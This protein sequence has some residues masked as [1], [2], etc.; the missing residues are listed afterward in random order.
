MH[1]LTRY[2]TVTA[3]NS[4]GVSRKDSFP[5]EFIRLKEWKRDCQMITEE[6]RFLQRGMAYKYIHAHRIYISLWASASQSKASTKAND[7]VSVIS[8]M[9][10]SDW[11]APAAEV[12][13][14]RYDTQI[15][16]LLSILETSRFFPCCIYGIQECLYL[17][18][19]IELRILY[20]D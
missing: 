20:S 5:N 2:C 18:F 19:L 16:V 9:I 1:P 14:C 17:R 13:V 8:H 6:D 15:P 3:D 7:D 11:R 12:N 4:R 10:S